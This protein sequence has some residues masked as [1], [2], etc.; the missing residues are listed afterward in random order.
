MRSDQDGDGLLG[1]VLQPGWRSAGNLK[2]K[3]FVVQLL[4]REIQ[5]QEVLAATSLI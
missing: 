3:S 2:N 4:M 1:R 5:Q